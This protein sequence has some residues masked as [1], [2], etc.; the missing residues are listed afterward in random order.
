MRTRAGIKV[1]GNARVFSK[2]NSFILDVVRLSEG[3]EERQPIGR[4]GF[5][6]TIG[7]LRIESPDDDFPRSAEHEAITT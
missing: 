7:A 2:G 6:E 5:Q 1:H 3:F 4:A